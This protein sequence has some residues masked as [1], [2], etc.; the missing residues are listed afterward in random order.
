MSDWNYASYL[1]HCKLW[2]KEPIPEPLWDGK[3]LAISDSPNASYSFSRPNPNPDSTASPL[4]PT[5][6]LGNRAFSRLLWCGIGILG[7]S[8]LAKLAGCEFVA[9]AVI[10]TL[11]LAA[12]LV[13]K[14]LYWA[15]VSVLRSFLTDILPRPEPKK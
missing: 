3:P 10:L 11:V 4:P 1:K 13:A 6:A 15:L 2:G 12:C 5:L 7:L 8:S 9:T 14:M